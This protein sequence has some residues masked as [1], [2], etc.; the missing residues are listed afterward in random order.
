MKPL[1]NIKILDLSRVLA[2]PFCTMILND[3]GFVWQVTAALYFFSDL[4][5]ACIFEP[6]LL[7]FIS[8]SRKSE[9]LRRVGDAMKLAMQKTTSRYGDR[10]GAFTL[11]AIAF[12]SDPMT[13]RSVAVAAGHGFF[14][15]WVFAITGDMLYFGVL[16]ISTLWLDGI[17]GNG[18][19]TT[20]IIMIAMIAVPWAIRR[21]RNPAPER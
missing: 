12:G 17:L 3:Q 5:L 9:R 7:I 16:M 18:T 21:I 14:M 1:E 11:I 15:G 20:V 19:W 4:I 6:L 2:G 8:F 10:G 13:G